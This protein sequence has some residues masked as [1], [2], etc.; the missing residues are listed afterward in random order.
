MKVEFLHTS[1]S[2]RARFV[3]A[4][5]VYAFVALLQV[6]PVIS[7]N[8]SEALI[9]LA[10]SGLLIIPLWFLRARSF[11]NKPVPAKVSKKAGTKKGVTKKEGI[12]RPVTMTDLDRLRAR[13][14]ATKKAKIPAL[15]SGAP[16]ALITFLYFFALIVGGAIFGAVG[17][18]ALV[19][20]YLVFFPYMWFA[21]IS[22]WYPE[23][24]SKIDI[25]A[26]ILD[27]EL[28]DNIR[29]KFQ[30]SPMIFFIDSIGSTDE[31]GDQMPSDVR[32]MLSPADSAPQELRDELLGVQFQITY[33]NGERGR[34]PYVY[35]VFITKGQGKIWQSLKDIRY[36][37]WITGPGSSTEGNVVYG[38]VVLRLNT[39][40]RSDGYHTYASDVRELLG[41]VV[42]ALEKI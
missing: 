37:R 42:K 25:L 12:W 18:F 29:G 28:P 8:V 30:F 36:S 26:P 17:F 31:G 11:S 4:F 21:Q 33:N 23:I 14:A 27:A 22:K 10:G 20:L 5:F 35:A 6:L 38:T 32:L 19:D 3:I 13:I 16:G 24:G 34:V 1:L 2:L 7:G 41:N 40:C 9:A 39:E 15:Y